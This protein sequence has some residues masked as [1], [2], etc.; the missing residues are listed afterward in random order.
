LEAFWRPSDN[1]PAVNDVSISKNCLAASSA[2]LL[3]VAELDPFGSLAVLLV[4]LPAIIKSF[5]LGSL[6]ENGCGEALADN[7]CGEDLAENGGG[8]ADGLGSTPAFPDPPIAV[9]S[10]AVVS[11][12][13]TP[14]CLCGAAC[15]WP[16]FMRPDFTDIRLKMLSFLASL[17]EFLESAYVTGN[18]SSASMVVV[19]SGKSSEKRV[20][21]CDPE[22][23]LDS[24]VP[25]SLCGRP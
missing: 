6:A 19:P 12:A 14:A 21:T 2:I 18:L 24:V 13:L 16:I 7:G 23:R 25:R 22:G 3:L 4:I 15:T 20:P 5:A 8:E 17:L 1:V 9:S 10:A 11:I